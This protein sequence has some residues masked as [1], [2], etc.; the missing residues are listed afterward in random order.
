MD[1]MSPCR[2][3]LS[4]GPKCKKVGLT[5]KLKI[6]KFGMLVKATQNTSNMIWWLGLA[7]LK[8]S[9]F[10]RKV[11]TMSQRLLSVREETVSIDEWLLTLYMVIAVSGKIYHKWVGRSCIWMTDRVPPPLKK[12]KP[13]LPSDCH[14]YLALT[15][16]W[17]VSWI[18][19]AWG[20]CHHKLAWPWIPFEGKQVR[21]MALN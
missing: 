5:G 17:F 16:N 8:M 21:G 13:Y 15:G 7:P 2:A 12:L 4:A 20:L 19:W 10:C 3:H 6:K 11:V 18:W 14:Y 9:T 1:P